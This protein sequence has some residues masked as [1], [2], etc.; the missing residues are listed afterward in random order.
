MPALYI[1]YRDKFTSARCHPCTC[2]DTTS[3]I[4]Y[5]ENSFVCLEMLMLGGRSAFTTAGM[6]QKPEG[7]IHACTYSGHCIPSIQLWQSRR[8]NVTPNQWSCLHHGHPS[9]S[10]CS[11]QWWIYCL[12]I[13]YMMTVIWTVITFNLNTKNSSNGDDSEVC[14]Y[15]GPA[16]VGVKGQLPTLWR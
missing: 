8:D 16:R 2:T 14:T 6:W 3:N 12:M 5:N 9:E 1:L 4:W 15:V 11:W 10:C 7:V 13:V